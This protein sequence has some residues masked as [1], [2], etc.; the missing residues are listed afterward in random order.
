MDIFTSLHL[1]AFQNDAVSF[2][3]Q[4]C[5]ARN[6]VYERESKLHLANRGIF[7]GDFLMSA[8]TLTSGNNFRKVQLLSNFAQVGW[9]NPNLY[10]DV[11]RLF[12]VPAITQY[13]VDCF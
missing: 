4:A 13:L 5:K 1:C 6:K 12:A 2:D 7:A 10:Y 11:R 3:A 9:L 8:A